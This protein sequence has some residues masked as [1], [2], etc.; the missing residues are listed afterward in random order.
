[1]A[2]RFAVQNL[3]VRDSVH[4]M[5]SGS[6]GSYF[7]IVKNDDQIDFAIR[8]MFSIFNADKNAVAI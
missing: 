6:R 3:I 7:S 8:N 1:M 4:D 2:L 5:N